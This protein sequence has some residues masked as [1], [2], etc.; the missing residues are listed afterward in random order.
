MCA[1]NAALVD[2]DP[3]RP[4]LLLLPFFSFGS[5]GQ[6]THKDNQASYRNCIGDKCNSNAIFHNYIR[7]HEG[8]DGGTH[9]EA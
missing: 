3:A 5:V 7:R 6:N 8:L 1:S 4:L 9:S 2:V